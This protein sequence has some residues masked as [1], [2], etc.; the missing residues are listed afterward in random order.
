[1]RDQGGEEREGRKERERERERWVG[2]GQMDKNNLIN[3]VLLIEN[4]KNIYL[5]DFKKFLYRKFL[6]ENTV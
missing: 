2:W 6:H 1:M 5:F 4:L 3:R